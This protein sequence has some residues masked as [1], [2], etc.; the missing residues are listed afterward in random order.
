MRLVATGISGVAKLETANQVA[1]YL[2]TEKRQ[3]LEILDGWTY[4]QQVAK[5][6]RI[7]I[8]KEKILDDQRVD[9]LRASSFERICQ[10]LEQIPDGPTS[11]SIVITHACFRWNKYLRKGFDVHYLNRIDPYAYI[12]IID[13]IHVIRKRLESDPQWKGR[14]TPPELVTWRD[15]ETFLTETLAQ[16]QRKRFYLLARSEPI[17]NIGNLIAD[18]QMKKIYLSY[19][20]TAILD[21]KPEL[22][23]EAEDFADELRKKYI[24]FNPLAIKDLLA[25][26]SPTDLATQSLRDSTVWR[27]FKLIDQSDMVVVYFPV[28]SNSPG[29]N[30]EIVYGYSHGKLVYLYYPH[31]LSP[32]WD[33]KISVTAQ[34]DTFEAL[35][36]FLMKDP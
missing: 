31:T 11:H 34:F 27:D 25:S 13:D 33:P 10:K 7:E 30:Q 9:L 17:S 19:P 14:L 29:V 24:V 15:E 6:L 35:R 18:P 12:N 21:E 22:L 5:D 8:K 1:S 4:I 3:T 2:Q 16:F 20:I 32:F 23:R 26:P 36:D 28:K